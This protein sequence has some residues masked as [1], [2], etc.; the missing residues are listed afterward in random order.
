MG[1]L[2]RKYDSDYLVLMETTL[3][4]EQVRQVILSLVFLDAIIVPFEGLAE[5]LCLR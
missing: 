2:M 3:N 4:E 5:G 1:T